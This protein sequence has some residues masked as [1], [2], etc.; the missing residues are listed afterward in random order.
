MRPHYLLPAL[1]FVSV[2]VLNCP[3]LHAFVVVYTDKRPVEDGGWPDGVLDLVNLSSRCARYCGEGPAGEMNFCFRGGTEALQRAVDKFAAIRA[4]ELKLIVRDPSSFCPVEDTDWEFLVFNPSAFYREY[5]NPVKPFYSLWNPYHYWKPLPPPTL[6]VNVGERIKW[7]KVKVPKNIEVSDLRSSAS[8]NARKGGPSIEG[9]VYDM[10]TGKTISDASIV[11]RGVQDGDA[12]VPEYVGVSEKDGRFRVSKF[13]E[14]SYF[15]DF[16]ASGYAG[17]RLYFG[18]MTKADCRNVN[19]YLAKAVS[20]TGKVLD[21]DGK[22]AAGATV[23]TLAV[24]GLDGSDY[25]EYGEY[26]SATVAEDGSFELVNVPEGYVALRCSNGWSCDRSKTCFQAP[27]EGIVITA[28]RTGAIKGTVTGP[29]ADISGREIHVEIESVPPGR[30][31]SF[32]WNSPVKNG[33]FCIEGVDPGDYSLT[34]MERSEDASNR[35]VSSP[36]PVTVKSGE[37]SETTLSLQK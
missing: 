15:V 17:R 28:Q 22:P 33:A 29:N 6:I 34:L 27:S 19:V 18:A 30:I 35:P 31:L 32:G 26:Y 4:P 10:G 14:G 11:F 2:A 13:P 16:N 24:H 9:V 8:S 25:S 21:A 37:T 7:N 3:Q 5:H 20:I 12:V 36:Y 1:L 23:G